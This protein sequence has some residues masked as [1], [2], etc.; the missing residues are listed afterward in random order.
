MSHPSHPAASRLQQLIEAENQKPH[1]H[2]VLLGVQSRDGQFTFTGAAGEAAPDSPYFIASITK[3]YTAAVIMQLVDEGRVDLDAALTAYLPA[4]LLDGIHVYR[5]VDYSHRLTVYQLLHQSSGLADYFEGKPPNGTSLLDDLKQGRDR[6]YDLAGTLA[7]TRGL[8]PQ[9]APEAHGGRRSFYSDTNFQLLGAII[10]AVTETP[11]AA[12]FQARLFDRLG[13]QHTTLYDHQT[14]AGPPPL[15]LYVRDRAI[16]IPQAM[17]SMGPDGG[18]VSTLAESLAFLQA[19]FGGEL[20]DERHF[21]RM[22]GQWNALF[23]PMRYGYGLMRFQLP[24]LLTLFRYSPEL[25]GHSGASGSFAYY[26]RREGLF[27]VGTFN[28]VDSPR[29][30]FNLMLT[31]IAAVV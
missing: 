28:Q 13:L 14:Y 11:L 2:S 23:F 1:T 10:E 8:T 6:A 22:M 16:H 7:I 31:A 15:P 18:I 19:F 27:L 12:V 30:P 9:F 21:A 17:S 25:V 5:G 20:F 3:M 24:R 4:D 29:R 26:A